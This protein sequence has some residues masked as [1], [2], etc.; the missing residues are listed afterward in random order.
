MKGKI[1]HTRFNI[2]L[3]KGLI[4]AQVSFVQVLLFCEGKFNWL[5][6]W[7]R[8]V[9]C[10]FFVDYFVVTNQ[11]SY[12]IKTTRQLIT[13]VGI[14]LA[15]VTLEFTWEM[16]LV[17]N[18][19]LLFPRRPFLRHESRA[20]CCTLLRTIKINSRIYWPELRYAFNTLTAVTPDRTPYPKLRNAFGVNRRETFWRS[21]C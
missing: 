14:V 18:L 6:T 20:V 15:Q 5:Y 12:T 4:D 7:T 11:A 19:R 8:F 10:D 3:V 1:P 13:N 9:K 16:D 17:L 21:L 2:H